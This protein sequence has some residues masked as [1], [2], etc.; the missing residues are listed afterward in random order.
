MRDF[1]QPRRSAAVSAHAMA[2]C[3]HP[4]ATL[5]ALDVLRA[6]GNAVD[7]AIATVAVLCVVE[8]HMTGIGGDCFVLYS[9]A[10]AAPIALNGS[11]RAPMK[12]TVD[13]YLAHGIRSIEVQTPH[14]VRVP[15]AAPFMRARSPRRSSPSSTV[16]AGCTR[17]RISPRNAASM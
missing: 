12:A 17:W 5:T 8:P 15:A 4:L 3:S 11:G 2:A 13:W 6:G 10:G 16:S 14:A 9:K 7:A 1:A